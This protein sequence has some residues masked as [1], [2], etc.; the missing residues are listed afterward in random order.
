MSGEGLQD[1][2][3]LREGGMPQDQ[4]DAYETEQRQRLQDGGLDQV[5]IDAYFGKG[6]I[7]T[8]PMEQH[9]SDNLKA[10]TTET[11]ADGTQTKKDL[12]WSDAM[13]AGWHGSVLGIATSK[14]LPS[15]DLA[16]T[17][18]Y[19]RYTA[20]AVTMGAD[21]PINAAGFVIGAAGG[22]E[23]GPG[24]LV[25]GAAGAF[26]LPAVLRGVYIDSIK[27]GA[28]N[29]P[30]EFI[31]RAMPIL[32]DTAKEYVKGATMALGGIAGRGAA[33][34]AGITGATL[35]TAAEATGAL[36]AMSGA[37][38]AVEGQIPSKQ[39]FAESAVMM[40][41]FHSVPT[42]AKGMEKGTD[43]VKNTLQDIY[44]KTGKPPTEVMKDAQ[45]DATVL[46]DVLSLNKDI[47]D[48]Y[49]S[50]VDPYFTPGAPEEVAVSKEASTAPV[51][52]ARDKILEKI[53]FEP[54]V[55]KQKMT[56]DQLYTHMVDSTHPLESI[57]KE[58]AAGKEVPT[59]ENPHTL[60][61]LNQGNMGRVE[62]A[63]KFGTFDFKTYEN[64]GKSLEATLK[65]VSKDLQ[66]FSAYIA[67]RRA[68]ELEARGIKSGF[69]VEAAK[70]L[71]EGDKAKYEPVAKD[72]Q[73]FMNRTLDYAEQAG[74]F[75]KE[76]KAFMQQANQ[77]YIPYHRVM[78]EAQIFGKVKESSP[79]KRIKGSDKG[80]HDP[81]ESVIKNTTL[82]MDMADRNAAAKAYIDLAKTTDNPDAYAKKVKMPIQAV[83]AT[84]AEMVKYLKEQ[85]IDATPAEALTLFR[86]GRRP[87]ADD[88]IAVYSDGKREVYQ[89]PPE[90]ASIYKNTNMEAAAGIVKFLGQFNK[91]FKAGVTLSPDFLLKNLTRDQ[92]MATLTSKNG[93]IPALDGIRGMAE[94]MGK[95]EAYQAWMKSGAYNADFIAA[96]ERYVGNEMFSL[97]NEYGIIA[98]TTNAITNPIQALGYASNLFE[99]ATRV[100]DFRKG[101]AKGGFSKE[102]I[103]TQGMASREL[104]QD[105][106]RRGASMQTYNML[107]AFPSA[108][109]GGID[110]LMRAIKED[111]K[112]ATAI[113]GATI[114]APSVL[115]WW[116]NKDEDWYKEDG[117]ERDMFWKFDVNG[118]RVRFVKPQDSGMLFGSG[119][120]RFL[121]FAYHQDPEGVKKWA[122]SFVQ[123]I[124][125]NFTPVVAVPMA[126]HWANKSMLTGGALIPGYLEGVDPAY[127]YTQYT[128]ETAK[129]LGKMIGYIPGTDKSGSIAAPVVVEN[130]IRQWSGGLGMYALKISDAGLRASG[131]AGPYVGP[132]KTLADIPVIKAWVSRFPSANAQVIQDFHDRYATQTQTYATL[133]YL[134]QTNPE[135]AARYAS[136]LTDSDLARL[137]NIQ[138]AL[139]NQ[140]KFIR[141]VWAD[142][143]MKPIEKRQLIERTYTEMIEE[144]RTGN[145]AMKDIDA[146]V[147][148]Q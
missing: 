10:A 15:E 136:S 28:I 127:Q 91:T 70:T 35:T 78:D 31:E 34:A 117:W 105:F 42:L 123:G 64:N 6:Q 33:G 116:M 141:N 46:Q 84:D 94:V 122:D 8:K 107:T 142:K 79:L 76:T 120:E 148:Q 101:V 71:V 145:Q 39:D 49:K 100:G 143:D 124:L 108:Q 22:A 27:N 63:I 13:S 14:Q 80:I 115:T 99:N 139:S 58:M 41:L 16:T 17:K 104:T 62:H 11:S 92:F 103:L 109:I 90:I 1:L 118:T 40:M 144:A 95:G 50:D 93:Y 47:P 29:S 53:Q 68:P 119:V 55:T 5:G 140:Q 131:A 110:R 82:L 135:L 48:M 126:E 51:D 147:S 19:K 134:K 25:T 96:G 65:P 20:D 7:N 57:V 43:Y 89:L 87:L 18:W 85:G 24:A 111:P 56:F 59:A 112:R 77:N 26:A 54:E 113:I 3:R 121:D 114:V 23:T 88:E 9:F 83:K 73:G 137:T 32:A 146:A 66:N 125:P 45:S 128:T 4:I 98:K 75:S 21:L 74:L 38:A 67:A 132:E 81:I 97:K 72:L 30:G 133:N 2:T 138:K 86:A 106:M 69:D 61:R 44:T 102:N 130:Y 36:T 129:L 52:I 37:S 60:L 12:S